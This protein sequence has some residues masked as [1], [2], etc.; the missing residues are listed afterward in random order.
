MS[1]YTGVHEWEII[2]LAKRMAQAAREVQKEC[3]PL[4]NDFDDDQA[5]DKVCKVIY[6]KYAS[7]TFFMVARERMQG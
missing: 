5:N 3:A 7:E 1:F 2:D 4:Q 6:N